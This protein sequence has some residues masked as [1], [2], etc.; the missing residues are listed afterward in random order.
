MTRTRVRRYRGGLAGTLFL[1]ALGLLYADPRLFAAAVVPLGY[2]AFGAL[3]SLSD[4]TP[5]TVERSFEPSSPAPGETVAVTLSVRNDGESALA[6]VRVVDGV[7][8]ELAVVSGSPRA[9]VALRPGESAT[10][11]YAVAALPGEYEF[12]DPAVRVRTVSATDRATLSV[13]AGGDATLSCARSVAAPPFARA[14]PRRVGTQRTDAGGEG[15]E[16]HSTREYRPGDSLSRVDWR[17]FA[18]TGDLTTVAFREERSAH[19]VVVVDARPAARARPSAGYPNGAT[20]CAYAA[21][22][23]HEALGGAGVATSVTAL[24]LLD[25]DVPDALPA[26]GLP[27]ADADG[28]GSAELVFEAVAHAADRDAPGDVPDDGTGGSLGGGRASTGSRESAAATADGGRPGDRPVADDET[29]RR[30]LAR[31]PTD[32]QVVLVSPVLDDR[33]ASLV[34]GLSARGHRVAVLAPDATGGARDGTGDA[35]DS[36]GRRVAATRRAARLRAL[37][38]AGATVV[39]WDVDDPLDVALER[40]LRSIV[41]P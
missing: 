13:A 41:N 33:P 2:V 11:S 24:G 36:P 7:P 3:S 25:E 23:L 12:E 5:P 9:A 31:L 4:A 6:D 32:A 37:R 34:R 10:L 29:V 38:T 1:A 28:V 40:S 30:L 19:A 35:G 16:F 21:Q 18:K 8:D 39:D 27:W 15:I 20:L 22:R 17:R 26:E 14:T